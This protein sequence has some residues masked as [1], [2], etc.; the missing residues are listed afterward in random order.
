MPAP[1]HKV[2]SQ[3][4]AHNSFELKNFNPGPPLPLSFQKIRGE[5][6]DT[7][8]GYRPATSLTKQTGNIADTM[9]DSG[10]RAEIWGHFIGVPL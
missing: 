2:C 3:Y 5:G 7:I 10:R 4:F 1:T 6:V 9:T 8:D